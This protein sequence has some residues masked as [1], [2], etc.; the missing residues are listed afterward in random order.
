MVWIILKR[1]VYHNDKDSINKQLFDEK[2]QSIDCTLRSDQIDSQ[3][4]LCVLIIF[5]LSNILH[6]LYNKMRN[7]IYK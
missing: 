2:G 5:I 7:Q 1:D 4:D 3:A 6:S